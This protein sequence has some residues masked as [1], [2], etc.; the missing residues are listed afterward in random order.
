MDKK[1]E[2][3]FNWKLSYGKTFKIKQ[4]LTAKAVTCFFF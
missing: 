1:E 4:R 3:Q 2:T